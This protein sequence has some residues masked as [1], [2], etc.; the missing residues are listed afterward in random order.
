MMYYFNEN[1]VTY[2]DYKINMLDS[3]TQFGI[4]NDDVIGFGL[5]YHF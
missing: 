1:M 5:T 4:T 3:N 2:V